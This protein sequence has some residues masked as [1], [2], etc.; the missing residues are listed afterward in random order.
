[1]QD[2]KQDLK[3]IYQ[4]VDRSELCTAGANIIFAFCF[5]FVFSQLHTRSMF[6]FLG[7]K[8]FYLIHLKK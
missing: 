7:R 2:T 3:E 8:V 1:M 5:V 4:T 6:S